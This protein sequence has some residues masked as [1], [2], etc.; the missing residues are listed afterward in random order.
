MSRNN[1][2]EI[3]GYLACPFAWRVRLAA[4]EKGVEADWIPC[5]VDD[6]DPRAARHNPH[7]NSPLLYDAGFSLLESEIIMLYLDE[8]FPGPALL[9]GDAQAR[10]RL[11]LTARKLAG[12]DV[13]TEPS[14]PQARRQ[15]EAAQQTLE[16]ALESGPYL[17]GDEPGLVDLLTW[18]FL[19]H[20]GVRRLLT[21]ERAHAYL[22]RAAARPSFRTTAPPWAASLVGPTVP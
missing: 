8:Q 7:E 2:V 14:R 6:P 17:H 22:A 10:A 12:L 20:L 1:A 4:A 21:G 13:H 19:A 11:R 18:P 5:D 3:H 9:A 16:A 15:S